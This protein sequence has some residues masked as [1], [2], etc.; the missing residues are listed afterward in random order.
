MA[1]E[2]VAPSRIHLGMLNPAWPSLGRLYVSAGLAV[3]RPRTVVRARRCREASLDGPYE[4]HERL[5]LLSLLRELGL[6]ACVEVVEAPPRHVGLGSTTQLLLATVLAAARTHGAEVDMAAVARRLGI[7]RRSGVGFHAFLRGGFIVDG[8]LRPGDAGPPPLLLRLEF[9]EEWRVVVA[10]P[11]GRGLA[12]AGEER[13]FSALSA[14]EAPGHVA[15]ASRV[16]FTQLLPA[17]VER[18]F[19][20][21]ARAL[22]RLQEIVGAIFG[23]VQGGTF[24]P[25]S[26][27][28]VRALRE[29]GLEGVGQSS[30]GP[31][32]YAFAD[33]EEKAWRA[34]EVARG[35]G[36]TVVVAGAS[37][38]GAR[39]REL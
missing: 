21:F 25:T 15:E 16:L 20:E 24:S 31:A 19:Q 1:V 4:E 34:L 26:A 9:P 6:A 17:V 10:L 13:A 23:P 36:A 32:I 5:A 35:L 11:R 22:G 18:D 38:A 14:L 37:N 30:W 12:G 7:G 28:L 39:A 33:G 27:E 8:G 2:V 3:D 29:A